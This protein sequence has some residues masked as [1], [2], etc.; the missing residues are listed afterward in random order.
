MSN[1]I[2]DGNS[3]IQ[4]AFDQYWDKDVSTGL[5][6]EVNISGGKLNIIEHKVSLNRDGRTCLIN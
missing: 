5:V 1:L 6:L 2:L 4:P 3:P